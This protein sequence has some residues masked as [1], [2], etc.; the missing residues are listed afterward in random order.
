PAHVAPSARASTGGG[1][2]SSVEGASSGLGSGAS[3]GAPSA[4]AGAA[5]LAKPG[6]P[7]KDV[8]TSSTPTRDAIATPFHAEWPTCATSYP[9]A[10]KAAA[11]NCSSRH[12]VS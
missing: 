2:S 3:V 4:G 12:L 11:G 1:T 6:W 5:G 8:S 9:A 10:S 7:G